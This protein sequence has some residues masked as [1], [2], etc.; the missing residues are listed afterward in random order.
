MVH[1]QKKKKNLEKKRQGKQRK[2]PW[3]ASVFTK[4]PTEPHLTNPSWTSMRHH[5]YW[6]GLSHLS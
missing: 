2:P 3:A 6:V 4:T 1:I 5:F